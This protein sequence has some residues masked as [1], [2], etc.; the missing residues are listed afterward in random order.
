MCLKLPVA[1][2]LG[3]F[4][5][6][7]C[8][9]SI[10]L[11]QEE[12]GKIEVERPGLVYCL[13]RVQQMRE[14]SAL[15]DLGDVHTLKPQENVVVFRAT[16]GYYTPVGVLRIAETYP[17]FC[18]AFPSSTCH[19]EKGDI[20][21]FVRQFYDMQPGGRHSIEF[22]KQQII[23]NSGD[24]AY[25]TDRR[26]DVARALLAYEK[27]Q[28]KWERSRSAI[29]GY[30]NGASF[31]E[32]REKDISTLLNQINLIR[33]HFRVG[34]NSLP[35]AGAAWENVMPVLFGA[36][37]I[38]QHESAQKVVIE[39]DDQFIEEPTGPTVRDIQRAIKEEFFDRT[40]EE[41]NLFSFLIATAL[42]KSPAKFDLWILQ[43]IEQSQFPEIAEEDVV[44][45]ILKLT[46]RKMRGQ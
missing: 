9:T 25:S 43:Q 5:A 30:L 23:K 46:I 15:I 2:F 32:G 31:A 34:R 36:T 19:P 17:T 42:E 14:G 35:A 22:A 1:I 16:E 24:N 27:N 18:R 41:R 44:V 11:C 7:C 21:M 26:L 6:N 33:E 4:A 20:A 10:A 40:E 37:A 45:D 8:S 13:G 38:A 39:G 12:G 3:L 29:V 28:P